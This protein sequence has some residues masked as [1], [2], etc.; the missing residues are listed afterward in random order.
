MQQFS[1]FVYLCV[2]IGDLVFIGTGT[3]VLESGFIF[4]GHLDYKA[5]VASLMNALRL[6]QLEDLQLPCTTYLILTV[7]EEI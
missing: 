2:Q 1:E 6:I 5:G 3:E 7:H 4:L